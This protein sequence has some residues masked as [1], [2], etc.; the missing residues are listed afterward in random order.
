MTEHK[1]PYTELNAQIDAIRKNPL[2]LLQAE[3]ELHRMANRRK[4]Y[5]DWVQNPESW[6]I[7]AD[8]NQ[9]DSPT[10]AAYYN[11]LGKEFGSDDLL[12]EYINEI[13]IDD[14]HTVMLNI[15]FGATS[16][17]LDCTPR[18]FAKVNEILLSDHQNNRQQSLDIVL[19]EHE[20]WQKQG[21][22]DSLAFYKV[23]ISETAFAQ[24]Q[25]MTLHKQS[26]IWIVPVHQKSLIETADRNFKRVPAPMRSQQQAKT[27]G[28]E[29]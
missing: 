7:V 3:T 9:P 27:F 28:M 11:E 18:C 24:D 12:K 25:G 16:S 10:R 22:P 20:R 26:R 19:D 6:K 29:M 5:L 15:H 1:A 2:L 4:I 21:R 17:L 23:P 8:F 13:E 14:H